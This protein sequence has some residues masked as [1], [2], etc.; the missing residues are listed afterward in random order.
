MVYNS[1]FVFS[2][3]EQYIDEYDSL[4]PKYTN[5][6]YPFYHEQGTNNETLFKSTINAINLIFK[7]SNNIIFENDH[8][9]VDS[10]STWN[11]LLSENKGSI[12]DNLENP[13]YH[14]IHRDH[15]NTT[16]DEIELMLENIER[17]ISKSDVDLSKGNTKVEYIFDPLDE[18]K[19]GA[20]SFTDL[21]TV[22][23]IIGAAIITGIF[24]AVG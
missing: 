9:F 19:S 4:Q 17:I 3:I 23:H 1:I 21:M 13:I 22:K 5:K 16:K 10:I 6:A 15:L 20:K 12:D 8:S 14:N 7:N 2:A 18:P 11:N 24:V